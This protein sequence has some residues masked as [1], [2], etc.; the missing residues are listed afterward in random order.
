MQVHLTLAYWLGLLVTVVLPILVG[1]VTSK[2]TSAAVKSVLLL[3]LSAANGFLVE[4]A[5][6]GPGYSVGT[7]AVLALVTFGAGVALHFGLYKPVGVS[8]VAQAA[9]VRRPAQ[10]T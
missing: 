8:A 1:L 9:G 5:H 4:L 6:P 7:A 2:V 10:S 3:G